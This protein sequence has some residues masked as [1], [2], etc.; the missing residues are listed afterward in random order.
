[1]KQLLLLLLAALPLAAAAQTPIDTTYRYQLGLTAS[2]QLNKFFTANRSLPLGLLYKR[3]VKPTQAVRA[4]L[5]GQYSRRDTANYAQVQDGTGIR[6]WQLDAYV[7]Y[8]WQRLLRKRFSWYYGAEVGAGIGRLNQREVVAWSNSN[9]PYQY[10]WRYTG[11][12]WQVQLR[13]FAGLQVALTS[14]LSVL[15]ETAAPLTYRKLNDQA[16]GTGMQTLADGSYVPSGGTAYYKY[17]RTSFA[18]RPIQ[19]IGLSFRL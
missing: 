11:K 6:E 18:W 12:R 17:T 5:V 8:E 16:R 3:Q 15:A 19:L 13:P 1:M 9:G 7:G 4:R 2:P 10:D 14:R